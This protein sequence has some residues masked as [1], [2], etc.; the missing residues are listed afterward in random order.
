M[1][2]YI[3]I[4]ADK[5]VFNTDKVKLALAFVKNVLIKEIKRGASATN[6]YLSAFINFH[7]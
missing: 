4:K 2:R 6:S 5:M 3:L 1:Y 7:S